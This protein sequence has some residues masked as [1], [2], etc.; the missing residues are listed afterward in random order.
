MPRVYAHLRDQAAGYLRNERAGH[1]LQATALVHETY[2]RLVDRSEIDWV[3]RAHFFAVCATCM[4]R[5]LVDHARRRMAAKRGGGERPAPIED[6]DVLVEQAPDR[7]LAL[8]E[9]MEQLADVDARKGR[10]A[11]L[12]LFSGLEFTDVAR[13]LEVSLSTVEKDWFLA[14]AWLVRELGDA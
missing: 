4:R 10:V 1:T 6:V 2:L 9:A 13:V 12:R 14:R 3:D 11:E 7:F 5:V 8:H